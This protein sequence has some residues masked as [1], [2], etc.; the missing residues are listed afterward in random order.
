VA[1]P[2]VSSRLFL[3]DDHAIVREAMRSMLEGLGHAVVGDAADMARALADLARVE[4]DVLLLDMNLGDRSGLEMLTALRQRQSS[5]GIVV[6]TMSRHPRDVGEALRLGAHG[7]VLK[8]SGPELLL[9][10]IEEAAAGRR[11]LDPAVAHVALG[12]LVESEAAGAEALSPRERQ[13]LLMVA[14]G[15]TSAAIGEE[16]HLSPKTV[17]SYRSRLMAKLKLGDV[18]AVVRWAIREGLMDL[19]GNV[20]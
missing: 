10:A 16:L 14:R 9:R 18:P 4:A 12:A 8:D 2:P 20:G 13:V 15:K 19:D 3:V 1:R 7:Y 5:L 17:D 6:L 11:F